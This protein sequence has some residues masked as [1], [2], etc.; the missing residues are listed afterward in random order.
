MTSDWLLIN[1]NEKDSFTKQEL[2]EIIDG[3]PAIP[4]EMVVCAIG[5]LFAVFPEFL[6]RNTT[7]DVCD[8]SSFQ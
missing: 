2:K 6:D 4:Y 1:L 8:V 3:T 7:R 5:D